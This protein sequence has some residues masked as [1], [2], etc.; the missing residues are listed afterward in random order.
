MSVMLIIEEYLKSIYQ[1]PWS[2][3]FG[4]PIECLLCP[5]LD[6]GLESSMILATISSVH[7]LVS[8]WHVMG[9]QSSFVESMNEHRDNLIT[10][11]RRV[12]ASCHEKTTERTLSGNSLI[13]SPARGSTQL[14]VQCKEAY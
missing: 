10:A 13:S 1:E 4:H 5:C 9:A 11:A 2:L 14:Q 7:S 3:G 8:D 6:K 12:S